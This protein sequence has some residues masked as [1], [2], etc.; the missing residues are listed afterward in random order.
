M[1][2]LIYILVLALFIFN[3]SKNDDDKSSITFLEKYEDTVWLNN[4]DGEFIYIRFI[5]NTITPLE[6][7]FGHNEIDCYYYFLEI[8]SGSFKLT[9]NS[10]DKLEFRINEYEEG[11]EYVD[12]VTLTVSGNS[13]K[14][15]SKYYEDGSLID[16]D[17]IYLT[18]TNEDVDSFTI[19][20]D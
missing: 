20:D 2:K 17:I 7:W 11:V 18:Q 10:D 19:C 5:N 8:S 4:D 6:S 13:L 15:E 9:E 12:I 3:C 1:K 16:T 14:V